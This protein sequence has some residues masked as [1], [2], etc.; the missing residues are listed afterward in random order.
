MRL[1]LNKKTHCRVFFLPL[2]LGFLIVRVSTLTYTASIRRILLR[3]YLEVNF[4]SCAPIMIS[5]VSKFRL[6]ECQH[7]WN[8]AANHK[9]HVIYPVVG[10]SCHN[11]LTSRRKALII[12]RLKI[13][14]CRLTHSYLLSGEDQPTCVSCNAP[15]T[16]KHYTSGLSGPTGHPAEVPLF[17]AFSS[18]DIFESVN[19]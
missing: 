17:T 12:N 18:K 6:E 1:G 15:L 4:T 14:H 13:A 10:T 2:H 7:I 19:N 11:S 9:L 8:S 5:R 16:V 3:K